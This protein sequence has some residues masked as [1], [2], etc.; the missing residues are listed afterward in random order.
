[1]RNQVMETTREFFDENGYMIVR[2]LFSEAECAAFKE[3][4]RRLL[5]THKDPS[6]V[7][8]GLAANSPVFREAARHPA[9]LDALEVI[10]GP[11]IEFL[12][13]KVVFKS[14]SVDFGSPWHQDWSY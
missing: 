11:N 8:V 5:E 14:A 1:M 9:L 2:G 10:Y 6:G 3:E 12:S 7:F 13:D 4:T